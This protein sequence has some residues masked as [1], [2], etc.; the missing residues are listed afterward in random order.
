MRIHA[1][2]VGSLDVKT[3]FYE[4]K[5][6]NRLARMTSMLLDRT[7]KNIP[8][9][10]WLIEHPEG[11]IVIDTG[12]TSR[13]RSPD[14]FPWMQR[15][16]WTSQFR[17][18]ITPDEEI[19]PQLIRR[20]ISPDDVRWV[21]ITHAH[22]DHTQAL[23]YFPNS[24][25]VF[26]RADYQAVQAFRLM[27][28]DFPSRWPKGL[29]I[30]Q[31]DYVDAPIGPF[32]ESY[33]LTRSGNVRLV[34]TPGHTLT[35]QSV[36]L[37]D[38]GLTYFFAGDAS[39]DLRSLLNG[40]IDAPAMNSDVTLETRKRIIKF[41]RTTPLIYMS[42][43]DPDNETRLENRTPLIEITQNTPEPVAAMMTGQ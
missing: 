17:F 31:I 2:K 15:P 8:V 20:G 1:I 42:T 7:F 12:L 36:V 30:N 4:G 11:T 24:E 32:E 27:R 16:Y 5:G 34:P 38:G 22:F 39:Y 33:P 23:Y 18:N 26:S 41:A 10:S 29:K 40:I 43:H 28:F 21:V 25:I 3:S 13:M 35:H 19:G 14:Y 6:K 37:S 9:Y